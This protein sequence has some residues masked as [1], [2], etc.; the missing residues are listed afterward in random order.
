MSITTFIRGF[1][2]SFPVLNAFLLAYN[3]NKSELLCVGI[4]PR[5]NKPN[6][7]VTTLLQN[8]LGNRD[9]KTRVFVPLQTSYS[10]TNSA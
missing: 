3:I 6:N 1:K 8:K 10:L 7:E 4:P 9:N 2:V 5:Y